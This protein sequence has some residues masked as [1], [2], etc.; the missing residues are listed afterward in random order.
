ML[1]P[2]KFK[3]IYKERIWGGEKLKTLFNKDFAPLQNVGESWELSDVEGNISV[4]SNGFLAGNDLR[5]LIEIYMGDLVGDHVYEEFG[6]AFPLLIKF[7]DAND[8]LSIQVHPDN[9]LALKR[10]NSYGKTEIW[11][12]LDATPDAKLVSGFVKA[13]DKEEYLKYLQNNQLLSTL[14]KDET[15]SALELFNSAYGKKRKSKNQEISLLVKHAKSMENAVNAYIDNKNN[16]YLSKWIL[17][18]PDS[19]CRENIRLLLSET[20]T[21]EEL[22]LNER[23]RLLIVHFTAYS[24]RKWLKKG[25]SAITPALNDE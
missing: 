11:Y 9:E 21:N 8:D 15:E 25:A 22:A 19:V 12:V 18:L 4:V 24:L 13:I 14:A 2:L 23:L 5:E 10:H 20:V 6:N 1:Y 17:D 3:P 16:E 7:L